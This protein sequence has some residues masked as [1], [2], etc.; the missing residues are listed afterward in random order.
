MNKKVTSVEYSDIT[1][2]V[3][4]LAC[5]DLR[6]TLDD[7]G[8]QTLYPAC[9]SSEEYFNAAWLDGEPTIM[10]RINGQSVKLADAISEACKLLNSSKAPL[11]SG[12]TTDVT[13]A[14][15]ALALADKQGATLDHRDSEA[16]FR[17]LHV[18]QDSGWMTTTLSEVRNRADMI[19]IVGNN[20]LDSFPRL[21]ERVLTPE[22]LFIKGKRK[23]VFIG[24]EPKL[25]ANLRNAGALCIDIPLES[26]VEIT[27]ILRALVNDRQIEN[28]TELPLDA[29]V[30]L[31][32]SLKQAAYA[33]I[34]WS[35]ADFVFPHAALAVGGWCAL[36][37]DLNQTTR[38][39]GL[40]LG[41]GH[42]SMSANQVCTWQAG[43]PLRS[44]FSEGHPNHHG[45]R[46][47]GTRML[48]HN[49]VDLLVWIA[50]LLP[51][52]APSSECPQIV[53]GHPGMHFDQPPAVYIPVGIP[54]IDHVGHC[55]RTDGVVALPLRQLR[56]PKYPSARE[57]I[58][59]ILEASC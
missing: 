35:A 53:I 37:E 19:V 7:Q 16:M 9:S 54:G 33:V 41:G 56:K 40:P 44:S 51:D 49:E 22:G 46:Y 6:V 3:C 52:E 45:W 2:P 8:L 31:A 29:L 47:N 38:A 10:P 26:T 43:F 15:A 5:D 50:T 18:L 48:L 39:A 1:C 58:D 55:F 14:R 25:P 21:A 4:G 30:E 32:N 20:V 34:A 27:G 11:I 13:G 17:N 28:P 42:G 59:Q 57:V 24:P 23:L 12:L 36:V